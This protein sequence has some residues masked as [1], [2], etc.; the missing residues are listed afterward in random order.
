LRTGHGGGNLAAAM[1]DDFAIASAFFDD[2][3]T[4]FASFDGAQV[5]A[6]FAVPGVALREDGSIVPLTTREDVV[7]YYQSALDF[8]RRQ[9][10]LICQ[11]SD[12]E[13]VKM[14]E[15]ALL[16]TVSWQLLGADGAALRAWRQSYALNRT[17]DGLK[18]FASASHKA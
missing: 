14:G 9:G 15:A 10:C 3:C 11:W 5:G 8:Y 2:F 17:A 16:A 12:L 7:R 18:V 1:S 4:A 6:L 13:I